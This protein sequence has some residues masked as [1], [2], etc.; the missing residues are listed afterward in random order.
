L[1]G[2]TFAHFTK[3]ENMKKLFFVMLGVG[4]SAAVFA[5]T[6]QP[7]KTEPVKKTEMKDLRSDVRAHK[8][9]GDKVNRDLSHVRVGKAMKDHAAVHDIKKDEHSDA[10]Q[11]REQ[12]VK[13]PISKA[14]RQV[15]VQDDNRKDHTE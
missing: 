4:I 8:T 14:K 6:E 3:I 1:T 2:D 11:L 7:K 15:K 9:A 10:K 12:G 5:Q 13:H